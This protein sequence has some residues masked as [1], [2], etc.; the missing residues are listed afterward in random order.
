MSIPSPPDPVTW[1]QL[2][3]ISKIIGPLIAVIMG[4]IIAAWR[5][6]DKNNEKTT[7]ALNAHVADDDDV[8]DRLFTDLRATDSK[9]DHLLGEHD[10]RKASSAACETRANHPNPDSTRLPP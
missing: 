5:S 10:S 6:M 7:E 2:E 9:L 1:D 3:R 4:L 8:H